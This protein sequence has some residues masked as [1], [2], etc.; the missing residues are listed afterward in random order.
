MRLACKISRTQGQAELQSARTS[1]GSESAGSSM[2]LC[3]CLKSN[4]AL[5]TMRSLAGLSKT[6]IG[7]AASMLALP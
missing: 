4:S 5:Q 6:P 2:L 3:A 1:T 7:F